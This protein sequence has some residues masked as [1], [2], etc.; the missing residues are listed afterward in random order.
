MVYFEEGFESTPIEL[1]E[2]EYSDANMWADI[3]LNVAIE[4]GMYE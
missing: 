4:K 3:C 1:E 2:E